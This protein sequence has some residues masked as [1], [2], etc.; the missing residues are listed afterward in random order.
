MVILV[1]SREQRPLE[2][3]CDFKRKGLKF[4]DYGC[5]F[6]ATY[7]Y[8]VVFERKGIGDLFGSLTY[9]Y[10]R[11]RRMFERAAKANYKVIIAIEGTREKV[12]N[13]YPH[14]ARDP[15]SVIKQLETINN[16]YGVAHIFF[17]SRIAMSHYICNYYYEEYIN[18]GGI[19]GKQI[20]YQRTIMYN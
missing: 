15:E 16:K 2:F 6:S 12:L 20:N 7:Q 9:G 11:F 8:P 3:G 17:P 4:G 18:Y 10:D 1:D 13:G 19:N 5:M 14:S